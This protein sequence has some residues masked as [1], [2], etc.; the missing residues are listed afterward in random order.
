MR[1]GGNAAALMMGVAPDRDRPAGV[2][3]HRPPSPGSVDMRRR[4]NL[5]RLAVEL[6]QHVVGV[7]GREEVVGRRVE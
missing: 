1:G 4:G 7:R 5:P 2:L 3:M 6:I